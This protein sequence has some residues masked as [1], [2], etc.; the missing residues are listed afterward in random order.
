MSDGTHSE[1]KEAFAVF[2]KDG[3]GSIT[4]SELG[5][6]LTSMGNSINDADLKKIVAQ[7]DTD[8]DGQ[9][10]FAEFQAMMTDAA[11]DDE[12]E[13]ID[14]MQEAFNMFDA[15]ADGTISAKEIHSVLVALGERVTLKDCALMVQSVD[16]DGNGS[17][18]VEEFKA[19]MIDK[20][21][22]NISK[23]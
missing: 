10:D 22:S 1:L 12:K 18:D 16:N 6:V 20:P 13:E 9:I 15:D 3:G 5:G 2:D 21:V 19:M 17:I 14:E 4:Y 23:A 8:G 11:S 7:F